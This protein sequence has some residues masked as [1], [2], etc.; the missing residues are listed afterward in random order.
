MFWVFKSKIQIIHSAIYIVLPF[1]DFS[2]SVTVFYVFIITFLY[3][4]LALFHF[5]VFSSLFFFLPLIATGH[6]LQIRTFDSISL[7][8]A[9]DFIA[10]FYT[11]SSLN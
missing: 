2:G 1:A 7:T 5:F 3:L 9:F 10:I 6:I 11:L 4:Y 8:P